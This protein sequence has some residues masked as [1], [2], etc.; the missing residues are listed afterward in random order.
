[1]G[2]KNADALDVEL[3]EVA[4]E[5]SL[6]TFDMFGETWTI[7]RKIPSLMLARL[8][9]IDEKDPEAIGTLDQVIEHALGKDAHRDFLA[10]YYAASPADGNDGELLQ[11]A[12]AGVLGASGRPTQ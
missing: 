12:L 5:E 4:G 7:V 9:R 10:L 8:A 2:K 11:E 3:S 1:M 6:A